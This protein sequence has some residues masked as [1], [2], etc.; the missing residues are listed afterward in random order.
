MHRALGGLQRASEVAPEGASGLPR[1]PQPCCSVLTEEHW[2]N[3][4]SC[5]ESSEQHTGFLPIGSLPAGAGMLCLPLGLGEV[6]Q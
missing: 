3:S 1:V 6:N 4:E 2:L 5:R